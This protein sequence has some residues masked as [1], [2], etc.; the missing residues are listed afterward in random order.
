[1]FSGWHRA[2]LLSLQLPEDADAQVQD[3]L[4]ELRLL[5]ESLG[6]EVGDRIVQTRPQIHP[7]TFFGKGKL[8][9][10][11]DALHRLEADAV[12]VDRTLSP[13]QQQN[14]EQHLKCL[15]LDRTQVIL[16]IFARNARSRAAQLQIRLAQSEY[17]FP[18]LMGLWQHLDRERGGIGLSRGMGEKQ[19]VKDRHYLQRRIAKLRTELSKLERER[20]TQKKR[21]THCLRVSLVGYTNAGKSTVMNALTDSELLVEDRLFATL[22]STTRLLQEGSR[23][24]VLLSDTVGFI[25]N[26]PTELIEAFKSTLET[27]RDADLL[28]QV[29]DA[30]DDFEAH[31]RTTQQVLEDLGANR[32][33][34][35]LVFN[36]TDQADPLRLGMLKRLY[37]DAVFIS[38]LNSGVA[39]LQEHI[40]TFFEQ[41][42]KTVTIRLDYQ[43]SQRLSDIYEWSRVDE[44]DYREEGIQMTLTSLPGYLNRLR[45]HLAPNFTELPA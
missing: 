40:R 12:V 44:I 27:V 20:V 39:R 18:R 42:M 8:D 28:L 41:R 4:E 17:L 22:D 6:C 38:A 30:N 35:Q 9:F 31:L 36:K 1:M 33:P 5:V 13:K 10:I 15:V 26:L 14:L 29:V 45:S 21:R 34:V 37:P 24:K 2:L 32:I 25:R 43:H 16:E 11:K 7:A 19:I 23:P 3:S